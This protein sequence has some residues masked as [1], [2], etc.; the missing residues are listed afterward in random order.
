M[1]SRRQRSI[2]AVYMRGGTSKGVFFCAQDL[3]SPGEERDRLLLRVIGSPDPYGKHTDGMG[4]ATSSTS[5]VVVVAKSTRPDSDVDYWFGAV[6]I[7]APVIDW[8]G[9]CGNLT[10]AVGPFAIEAG[11]VHP[12]SEGIAT[13]R[14]WQAGIARRIIARVPVSG[15]SVVEDGDFTLDGV[16]FPAAEIG[17]EFLE[18][19]AQAGVG[20]LFPTGRTAQLLEVPWV[21]TLSVT[22]INAGNPTIFVAAEALGLKGMELQRDVN[23]NQALLTLVEELRVQGAMAMGLATTAEEATQR[24]PH[25]PKVMYVAKAQAYTAADGRHVSADAM[26]LTVRSF[27]MGLLHHAIPGTGAVAV[28]AAAAIPGTVVSQIA[29]AAS[30]GR[31]RVGHPSG[32]VEVGADVSRIENRWTLSK[33]RLSRSARRLMEGRVYVPGP[34]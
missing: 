29:S 19:A 20:D 7:D 2:P 1:T 31:L 6:S 9:N 3:P 21:G 22:L 14:L 27:S 32:I 10:A 4:G 13:L 15:G 28:A 33:A 25:T 30:D 5:K 17:L 18:P 16:A 8:S 12:P 23:S 34:G 24:R 26:D 11:L